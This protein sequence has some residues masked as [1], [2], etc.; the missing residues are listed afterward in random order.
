MVKKINR[1]GAPI[2]VRSLLASALILAATPAMADQ[3]RTGLDAPEKASDS[4]DK[5]ICKRFTETGSLVKSYR[6]CKTKGEWERERDNI[7]QL[8]VADSC[9]LR[10]EGGAC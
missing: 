5:L 2:S 4:H 6:S 3:S 7:R 10:A 8:S 9:R 1:F